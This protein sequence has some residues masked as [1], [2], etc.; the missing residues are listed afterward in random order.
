MGPLTDGVPL[1]M[2][3]R[4]LGCQLLCVSRGVLP[5]LL[6]RTASDFLKVSPSN[7][8]LSDYL[9]TGSLFIWAASSPGILA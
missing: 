1:L 7:L 2:E 9:V 3:S 5:D 6:V 4:Y 8:F